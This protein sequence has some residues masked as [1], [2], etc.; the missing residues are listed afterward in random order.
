MEGGMKKVDVRNG[1]REE[2]DASQRDQKREGREKEV[3]SEW[4]KINE[5]EHE[6]ER[7]SEEK[8]SERAKVE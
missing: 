2:G 7:E 4:K 3:G 8:W 6:G 5:N 1:T